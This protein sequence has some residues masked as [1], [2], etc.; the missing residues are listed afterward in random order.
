MLDSEVTRPALCDGPNTAAFLLAL[1]STAEDAAN[2][3]Q[4]AFWD[5][6]M[7]RGQ[8][9]GAPAAGSALI[10]CSRAALYALS[11]AQEQAVLAAA[12]VLP[13]AHCSAQSSG[14]LHCIAMQRACV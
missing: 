10:T 7:G 1:A 14:V 2:D 8:W 3:F 9:A 5:A 11:G 4:N 13:P 6:R 12:G